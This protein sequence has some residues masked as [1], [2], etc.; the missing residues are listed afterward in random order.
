MDGYK[1]YKIWGEMFKL[2]KRQAAIMRFRAVKA[3]HNW[4]SFFDERGLV[5]SYCNT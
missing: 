2:I 3:H 1:I 5:L 4:E